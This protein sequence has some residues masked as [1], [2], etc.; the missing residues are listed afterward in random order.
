MHKKSNLSVLF[1]GKKNDD[2]C[3]RALKFVEDNFEHVTTYYSAWGEPMP[4]AIKNWTGDYILSYL[5]RWVV[6]LSVIENARKAAINFHP[7]SPDYPG[8]GCNN[9]ALYED[10][11]E[12]GVT[13]HHMAGKVD[14]GKI[15]A[16]KRFSVYSTDDVKSLLFRAYDFQ[17][18]LFYEVVS[19]ILDLQPLPVSTE[20]WTKQPKSRLEFNKLFEILPE[21]SD[22]EVRRRVRAVSY[23]VFQ[24]TVDIGGFRFELKVGK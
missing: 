19:T 2:Y 23:G 11:T 7:A 13:C 1:L 8:I 16:V 18:V 4:E 3:D 9:Y 20:T 21:M 22:D 24:P 6:P 14:T 10:A 12:Y 17:L 15:I 5:C